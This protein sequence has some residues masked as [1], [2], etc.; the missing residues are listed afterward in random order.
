MLPSWNGILVVVSVGAF[1]SGFSTTGA[2]TVFAEVSARTLADA[3]RSTGIVICI[4]SVV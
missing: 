4:V 3:V 1:D 2:V